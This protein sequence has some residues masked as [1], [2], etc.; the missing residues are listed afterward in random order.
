MNI[1]FKSTVLTDVYAIEIHGNA[2]RFP[3]KFWERA[4]DKTTETIL[5]EWESV[6]EKFKPTRKALVT[7]VTE[8]CRFT[9]SPHFMLNEGDHVS[10]NF[11]QP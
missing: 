3:K 7:L 1:V 9:F 2:W 11:K 5:N 4:T 6:N 10:V 8:H